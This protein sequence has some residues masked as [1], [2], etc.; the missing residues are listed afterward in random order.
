MKKIIAVR[1]RIIDY[2]RFLDPVITTWVSCYRAS[3]MELPDW[4]PKL[5][6]GI[7][8]PP[9]PLFPTQPPDDR[10]TPP[11]WRTGITQKQQATQFFDGKRKGFL[12]TY[13]VRSLKEIWDC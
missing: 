2:P 7:P 8:I 10:F 4:A 5:P 3:P 1:E 6:S 11:Q 12:S 9:L 13:T